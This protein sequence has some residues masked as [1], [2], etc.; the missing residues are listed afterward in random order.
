MK[1]SKLRLLAI[2]TVALGVVAWT[3]AGE[4]KVT[5]QL[6]S[7]V[8]RFYGATATNIV[9]LPD[10]VAVALTIEDFENGGDLANVSTVNGAELWSWAV[11]VAP[12]ITAAVAA[13]GSSKTD[14]TAL[15]TEFNTVTGGT[16]LMGV[17]LLTAAPGV[18]QKI[19]NETAVSIVAYPLDA[20]NDTLQVDNFSA[21][22]ADAGW[23]IGPL[24]SLDCTAYSTTAWTCTSTFGAHASVAAAGDTIADCTALT[25]V[26]LNSEVTVTGAD[27]TKAICLPTG[28]Y[29]GCIRIMSSAVTS[30]LDVFGNNSDN[31]TIAGAAADAVF[32][33]TARTS[34]KYCTA[35][36]V[37]WLT[38]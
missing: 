14:C 24:G 1:P 30:A 19:V 18:H 3:S 17:C 13:T 31:D 21:L 11:P 33:Q 34:L 4:V 37:A 36:G 22:A 38:R 27:G 25:S 35:D 32:V 26:N 2:L 9:K 16:A 23:V 5:G 12:S 28:S 7:K 6:L 8:Q 29:P 15:T 20:G 10:N